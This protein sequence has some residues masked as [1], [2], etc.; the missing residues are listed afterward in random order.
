MEALSPDAG[1]FLP[2]SGKGGAA[3]QALG[4]FPEVSP[5]TTPCT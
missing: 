2:L 4:T 1:A 5:E 3:L